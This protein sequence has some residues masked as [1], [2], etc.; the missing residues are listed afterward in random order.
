MKQIINDYLSKYRLIKIF[1]INKDEITLGV[2]SEATYK[3][4]DNAI[5]YEYLGNISVYNMTYIIKMECY[6]ERI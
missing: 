6:G 5:E 1:F 3:I 2:D 4:M